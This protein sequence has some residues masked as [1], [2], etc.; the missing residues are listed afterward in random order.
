[1]FFLDMKTIV[2]SQ[3]ISS[4]ICTLVI[5]L[6][7]HHGRKHFDGLAFWL[8]D[9]CLQVA[10][11]GLLVLRGVVPDWVSM[12]GGNT[13]L[14]AGTV[15]MY[16][17]LERF[18]GKKGPQLHNYVLLLVFV[19]VHTY[20]VLVQ[21][22]L[23]ARNLNLLVVLTLL[24]GQ[25]L[26][27]LWRRVDE[28]MRRMTR[29][30]ALVFGCYCLLCIAR[31]PITILVPTSND[32]FHSSA[33]DTFMVLLYQML[34]VALTL[35]LFLMVNRRLLTEVREHAAGK[36][37]IEA[38]LREAHRFAH[39]GVWDWDAAS[40][41]VNW[42]EELF[43]IA[44][45]D[46]EQPAPSYAEHPKVYTP[47]GWERLKTAVE[48]AL[49]TGDPY[50]LELELTRPDGTSRWVNA[51]G[52]ARRDPS[53]RIMGLHGM[54]QDT[55]ER[56]LAEQA[57]MESENQYRSLFETM[58]EGVVLIAPDGRIVTANSAAES[59]LG[60]SRSAIGD[61]TYDSPQWKLLRSDGTTMPP[62]EMAGSIAMKEKRTVRDVGFIGDVPP[63][64]TMFA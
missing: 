5:A 43:R 44:G 21:P 64:L 6:L 22:S 30:V 33:F 17:G 47:E 57:L 48:R 14:L 1:M 61:R 27:L 9:Y 31:V 13:L 28:R 62:E 26:W 11:L 37:E 24:C 52:G 49:E 16:M 42:T 7:W 39:I 51:F 15:L 45:R 55:T 3:V 8:V 4:V 18:V 40:D 53:G 36:E 60:L 23:T 34:F 58:A 59:I 41:T 2:F 12:V 50:Q 19:L 32:F 56:R 20:F 29:E 54:V 38:Q 10:A 35:G 25:C 46:P 63:I